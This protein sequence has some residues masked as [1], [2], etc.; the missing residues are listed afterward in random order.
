MFP[1][2]DKI[3]QAL[4]SKQ[5]CT[6]IDKAGRYYHGVFADSWVRISGGKVRGKVVFQSEEKGDVEI[7]GNHNL[8]VL[9]PSR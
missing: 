3:E 5:R 2:L 1:I 8:D 6:L 9:L 4:A 7:D